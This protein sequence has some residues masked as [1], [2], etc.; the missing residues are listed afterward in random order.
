MIWVRSRRSRKRL[1]L[2]GWL[3]VVVALLAGTWW[4]LA[5]GPRGAEIATVL[6]LLLAVLGM[7]GKAL[8]SFTEF[9]SSKIGHVTAAG[10]R[11]R[12]S[13]WTRKIR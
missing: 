13:S 9:E 3:V 4:L 8:R 7:L 12:T 5:K 10:W 1:L 6:A 11:G 2:A